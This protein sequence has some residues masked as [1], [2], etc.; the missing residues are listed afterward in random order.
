MKFGPY[1]QILEKRQKRNCRR[2]RESW[3]Y[4]NSN[5]P[6]RRKAGTKTNSQPCLSSCAFY[7]MPETSVSSESWVSWPVQPGRVHGQSQT[8]TRAWSIGIFASA[9]CRGSN[10]PSA[11]FVIWNNRKKCQYDREMSVESVS[12]AI[13]ASKSRKFRL[14]TN[15]QSDTPH[16]ETPSPATL[17][18]TIQVA[19]TGG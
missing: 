16:A 10:G 6:R 8:I 3:M 19:H 4:P 18:C 15:D 11:D 14:P 1:I 13:D 7:L 17:S 2:R 12:P 9:A 5:P